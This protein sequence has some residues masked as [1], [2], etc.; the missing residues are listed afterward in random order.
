MLHDAP[1]LF[2]YVIRRL[3]GVEH[4]GDA[5]LG[6][7]DGAERRYRAGLDPPHFAQQVGR[8]EREAPGGAELAVQAFQQLLNSLDCAP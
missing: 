1:D 6:V 2:S 5:A 4:H 8:A 3:G 7:V